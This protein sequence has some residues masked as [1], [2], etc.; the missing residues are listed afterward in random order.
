RSRAGEFLRVT[1][2]KGS[3][4]EENLHHQHHLVERQRNK[5]QVCHQHQNETEGAQQSTELVRQCLEPQAVSKWMQQP[6]VSEQQLIVSCNG[7]HLAG[8]LSAGS[9]RHVIMGPGAWLEHNAVALTGDLHGYHDVVQQRIRGNAPEQTSANGIYR[10]CRSNTGIYQCFALP[11][12]LL[13]APVESY[14][15]HFRTLGQLVQ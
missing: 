13:V 14:P 15:A 6:W 11:D 5:H 1:N 10:A 12:E 2:K 8:K 9:G 4:I 3:C 7:S